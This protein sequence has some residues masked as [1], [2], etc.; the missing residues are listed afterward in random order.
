MEKILVIFIF[1]LLPFCVQ[2]QFR[3]KTSRNEVWEV[4]TP[5]TRKDKTGETY[6][7]FEANILTTYSIASKNGVRNFCTR[8][9][10][11]LTKNI[12]GTSAVVRHKKKEVFVTLSTDN[13]VTIS[14]NGEAKKVAIENDFAELGKIM[15]NDQHYILPTK[16]YK[17]VF[18]KQLY[19]HLPQEQQAEMKKKVQY[20]KLGTTKINFDK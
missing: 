19:I 17:K 7:V 20:H 5:P 2:A 11:D 16:Y 13:S 14:L 15:G 3:F 6:C 8:N 18:S 4:K 12:L 10:F 1:V 9:I